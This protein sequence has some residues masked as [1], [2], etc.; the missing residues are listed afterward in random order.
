MFCKVAANRV[1]FES[2]KIKSSITELKKSFQ[3]RSLYPDERF[4]NKI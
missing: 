3:N 1:D 4:K 2:E